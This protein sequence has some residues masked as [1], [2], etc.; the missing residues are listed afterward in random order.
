M[1]KGLRHF[2]K[3]GIQMANK[4]MKRHPTLLVIT[5]IQIKTTVRYHSTPTRM[6]IIKKNT[7]REK[8]T[9]VRED[10]DK[11]EPSCISDGNVK[12][13]SRCGIQFGSSSKS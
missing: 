3:E 6:A 13:C 2:S 8:I 11:L 1:G 9:T 12:W 7:H 4:H 10:V 5:G